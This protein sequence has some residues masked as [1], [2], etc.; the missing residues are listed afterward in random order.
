MTQ[1]EPL[2]DTM[3]LDED[4]ASAP[5]NDPDSL[6]K[7]LDSGGS[8][9]RVDDFLARTMETALPASEAD[10]P[11]VAQTDTVDSSY[12]MEKDVERTF[13]EE[14][15]TVSDAVWID[16]ERHEDAETEEEDE[17]SDMEG[18][19][20]EARYQAGPVETEE[21]E[22]DELA[23]DE[24]PA[25]EESPA[26]DR[27]SIAPVSDRDDTED[28]AMAVQMNQRAETEQMLD[29][30][31]E[32]APDVK[33]A[34]IA[35]AMPELSE[36]PVEEEAPAA[37]SP[38]NPART[39]PVEDT[40]AL[41]L[42][43]I[44]VLNDRIAG[45]ELRYDGALNKI[46]HALGVIAERIDGLETRI[47]SKAI[48]NVA[49][50]AAPMRVEDESVAPYIAQAER[51]LA[52][53]KE[54]GS[55][56]IFERIAQAAETEFDG[57]SNESRVL[58]NS[59]DGR[60]VGTKRWQP[61]KT[62]KKRMEQLEQAKLAG[63]TA[64][65][66]G[67]APENVR[68]EAI[69]TH[70][71]TPELGAALVEEE[72]LEEEFEDDDSGLSVVPGARGRRRNRA[73]KSRL[74]EDFENV[75]EESDA[76]PSIQSLRRKMRD[77]PA[78]EEE[79]A[80]VAAKPKASKSGMVGNMLGGKKN[81]AAPSPVETEEEDEDLMAAFDSPAESKA[82][83]KKSKR[84][85]IAADES[86]WDDEN[87]DVRKGL[88]SGPLLYVMVAGIAAACFFAWQMFM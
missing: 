66:G 65:A 68:P 64:E 74:D 38:E 52:A 61:S 12:G 49:M 11:D 7:Q 86:E 48:N 15:E 71:D 28:H 80:P 46:G 72:V 34:D 70:D 75:F 17:I 4:G 27:A 3:D 18:G 51:E 9:G 1:G 14:I 88:F 87:A 63:V 47:T 77:R 43:A 55:M 22:A 54:K 41:G 21:S 84:K 33:A 56:D 23:H 8:D 85:T 45:S 40:N 53:K 42:Q 78:E 25:T 35:I 13:T 20:E 83:G 32:G 2:E 26:K 50:V 59:T 39:S 82:K 81:K 37:A 57:K 69:P 5:R 76:K 6:R 10:E 16:A 58:Q 31:T 36:D 24:F 67:K 30:I 29:T 44:N 62:V 60:R 73:R 79:E 19:P